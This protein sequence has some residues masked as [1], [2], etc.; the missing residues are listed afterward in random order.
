MTLFSMPIDRI[1]DISL[2]YSYKLPV[3][4]D[5]N[6]KKQ[7]NIVMAIMTL[8]IIVSVSSAFDEFS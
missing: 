7:I 2:T 5:D 1:T 6:E 3:M 4:E 8:K